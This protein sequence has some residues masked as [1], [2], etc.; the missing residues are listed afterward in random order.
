M[1]PPTTDA[2]TIA[3]LNVLQ[4][5]SE[6]NAR[7]RPGFDLSVVSFISFLIPII[8]FLSFAMQR[9]GFHPPVMS[10][11]SFSTSRGCVVHS[12][13]DT[14]ILVFTIFCSI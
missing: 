12:Y 6:P 14:A 10:F 9:G 13:F 3:G 8:P 4:L 1:P 2:G 11:L 7:F 5:I